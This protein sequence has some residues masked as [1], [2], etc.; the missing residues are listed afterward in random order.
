MRQR[1]VTAARPDDPLSSHTKN[2]LAHPGLRVRAGELPRERRRAAHTI[3]TL[4]RQTA[5]VMDQSLTD[6]TAVTNR[7]GSRRGD[8]LKGKEGGAG[9]G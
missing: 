9:R 6:T 1:R 8:G 2:K 5:E 4:G 7:V 3:L